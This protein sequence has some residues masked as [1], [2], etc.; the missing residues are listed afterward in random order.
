MILR[1][2][3]DVTIVVAQ[4]A[5]QREFFAAS[6]LKK[7]LGMIFESDFTVKDA[8][9]NIEGEKIIIGGPERN[10]L[11]EKY[12]SK[13]EFDSLTPGPEGIFIKAYDDALILAGSSENVNELERGTI[14]AVYEFLERFLGCSLCAYIKATLMHVCLQK[15]LNM[16]RL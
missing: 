16:L 1:K 9:E 15:L 11:S 12:I 14:Y 3:C 7:Y 5:T 10:S 13:E 2:D 6:E 4:N 8:T